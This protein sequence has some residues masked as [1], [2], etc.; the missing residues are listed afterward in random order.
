MFDLYYFDDC[1]W[2]IG[3]KDNYF[4]DLSLCEQFGLPDSQDDNFYNKLIIFVRKSG[5]K[6]IVV[7]ARDFNDHFES[8][9]EDYKD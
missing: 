5:G 3:S 8:N 9:P 1:Y 2:N 7:I 6:E 4:S